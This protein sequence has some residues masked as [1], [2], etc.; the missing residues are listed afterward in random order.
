MITKKGFTLVEI[1]VVV[2]II[3]ILSTIAIT[4][5]SSINSKTKDVKKKAD[6]DAL[7]NAYELKYNAKNRA[8]QALTEADFLKF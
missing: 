7:A 3:A 4:Y 5:F 2:T 6:I 1:L 8:Y